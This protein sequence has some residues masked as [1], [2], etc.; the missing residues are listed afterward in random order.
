MI[1]CGH[2]CW[3]MYSRSQSSHRTHSDLII[4]GPSITPQ[5]Q[6]FSHSLQLLHLDHRLMPKTVRF[7]SSPSAAPSGQRNLHYRF[8][9]KVVATSSTPRAT[10][11]PVVP[12]PLNIQNGST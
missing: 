6:V 9:T 5:W 10:H 11:I 4:L 2:F 12:S 3:S 8:P 7:E 1:Q